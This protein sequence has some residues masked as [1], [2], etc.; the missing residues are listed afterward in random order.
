MTSDDLVGRLSDWSSVTSPLAPL[1]PH[2]LDVLADLGEEVR[3]R[4]TPA[5]IRAG[6]ALPDPSSTASVLSEGAEDSELFPAFSRLELGKARV[7]TGQ[8]FLHWIHQVE[9]SVGGALDQPY[10]EHQEELRRQLAVTGGL[11]EEVGAS[12][13]LLDSLASQYQEVSRRTT[14]LHE[15][16]QH[17][18]EEQQQLATLDRD[19][20]ERLAVF[21]QADKVCT[22]TCTCTCTR[23][24]TSCSPPPSRCTATPSSPSSPA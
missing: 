17:L 21:Q 8:Q 1:S 18:L 4:A 12:L 2:Q 19:L 15:A 3:E 24:P 7:D 11:Q 10:R 23:W 22:C 20:Q 14:S 13:G 6:P 5:H 9:S 16:C